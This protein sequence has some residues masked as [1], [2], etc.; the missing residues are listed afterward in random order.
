MEEG[1]HVRGSGSP[2]STRGLLEQWMIQLT[3]SAARGRRTREFVVLSGEGRYQANGV[4][5][6]KLG[7]G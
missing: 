6:G 3:G 5:V 1:S 4:Q 2:A 7:D